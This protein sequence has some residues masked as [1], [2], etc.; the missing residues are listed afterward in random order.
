[1]YYEMPAAYA[2][3][4]DKHTDKQKIS[5]QG[6]GHERW[7]YRSSHVVDHHRDPEVLYTLMCEE[8]ESCSELQFSQ[9]DVLPDCVSD[10]EIL[11]VPIPRTIHVPGPAETLNVQSDEYMCLE[12]N[13]EQ[14]KKASRP[15][16]SNWLSITE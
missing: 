4:A 5:T 7:Y 11:H 14:E 10:C 15:T 9:V 6:Q 3:D 1:M 16:P 8:F 13:T 12:F 2:A